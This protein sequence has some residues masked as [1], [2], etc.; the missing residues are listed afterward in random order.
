MLT[1]AGSQESL[2]GAV[3]EQE[4]VACPSVVVFF[5]GWRVTD[6]VVVRWQLCV[7]MSACGVVPVNTCAKRTEWV[8]AG[9]MGGGLTDGF[10]W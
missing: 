7:R 2:Q 8:T 9:Q 4:S 10:M 1:N 5:S 3:S 6:W